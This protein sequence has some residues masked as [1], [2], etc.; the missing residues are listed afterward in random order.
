M[1]IIKRDQLLET[2]TSEMFDPERNYV[3]AFTN[4]AQAIL[5]ESDSEWFVQSDHE[6]GDLP[7]V[8]WPYNSESKT[9]WDNKDYGDHC[10]IYV[11]SNVS[12]PER[13]IF[14]CSLGGCPA[15]AG[16]AF[17]VSTADSA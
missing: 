14:T 1:F 13:K 2:L 3:S 11:S 5:A 9:L 16:A 4:F 8:W 10:F 12:F 15:T 7:E 6:N 17:T